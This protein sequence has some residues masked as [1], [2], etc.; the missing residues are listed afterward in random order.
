MALGFCTR[1]IGGTP[2]TNDPYCNPLDII[3]LRA[4][5]VVGGTKQLHP[6]HLQG[7]L[8]REL[9]RLPPGKATISKAV[10]RASSLAAPKAKP[11]GT[12]KRSASQ[13]SI[14]SAPKAKAVKKIASAKG[15][16]ALEKL[17]CDMTTEE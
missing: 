15:R 6:H 10:S 4:T 16:P 2:P 8:H 7:G 12:K 5:I 1:R 13:P 17:V 14:S 9:P 3:V 11:A